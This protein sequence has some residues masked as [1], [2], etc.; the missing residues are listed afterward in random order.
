MDKKVP[1]RMCVV[2]RKML[3]KNEC[4]RVVKS[5]DGSYVL[6]TTGKLNGRGAYVCKDKTC[7]DKCVK[8]HAFNRS[9]KSNVGEEVYTN[10]KEKSVD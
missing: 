5:T 4:F 7:L 3:P 8:T 6:D 2:C 9:F 10:I 1:L